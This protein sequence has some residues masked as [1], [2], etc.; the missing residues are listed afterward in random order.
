MDNSLE[1]EVHDCSAVTTIEDTCDSNS[2]G[3]MVTEEFFELVL[4]GK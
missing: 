3:D 2:F 4:G 1:G